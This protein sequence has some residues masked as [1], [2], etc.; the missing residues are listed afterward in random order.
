M[1]LDNDEWHNEPIIEGEDEM[2]RSILRMFYEITKENQ[3]PIKWE[4]MIIKS[5]YRDRGSRK[6]LNDRRGLIIASILSNLFETTLNDKEEQYGGKKERTTKDNWLVL[7]AVIE[8]RKYL[9]DDT[10]MIFAGA[11]KCF[12]QFWLDDCLVRMHQKGMWERS[13]PSK[14]IEWEGKNRKRNT[15]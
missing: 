6:E 10:L 7:M 15:F 2:K 14:Q 9:G 13:K 3:G 12:D 8:E 1:A 4:K 11:E 5:V